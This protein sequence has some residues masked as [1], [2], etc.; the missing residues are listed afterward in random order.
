M[1]ANIEDKK[2]LA[3][4]QAQTQFRLLSQKVKILSKKEQI[5]SNI[6]V[7]LFFLKKSDPFSLGYLI[8]TWEYRTFISSI[9]LE[10]NAFDQYGVE[11]GKNFTREFL[12][13][14]C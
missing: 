5:N 9:L 1:I 11:A 3:Y 10:I 2:S 4:A 6:P 12:K 14:N 7:N 13:E 8:A